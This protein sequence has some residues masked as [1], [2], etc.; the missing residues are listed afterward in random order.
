MR[1]YRSFVITLK[2]Y[3][4]SIKFYYLFSIVINAQEVIAA[5]NEATNIV[6]T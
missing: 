6:N 3:N 1:T 5:I 4:I 2:H